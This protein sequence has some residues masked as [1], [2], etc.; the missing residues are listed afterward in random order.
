M[1]VLLAI[2]DI[3]G[4]EIELIFDTQILADEVHQMSD[5]IQI[6]V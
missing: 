5:T 2:L 6:F 3:S 1:A 4:A